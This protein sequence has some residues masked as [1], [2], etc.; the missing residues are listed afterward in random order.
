MPTF[1]CDDLHFV[2][3]VIGWFDKSP[4]GAANGFTRDIIGAI[5]FKVF[6]RDQTQRVRIRARAGRR[7]VGGER[8]LIKQSQALVRLA[9]AFMPASRSSA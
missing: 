7:V 6:D 3:L 4:P 9:K 8:Q 1:P 5:A 2:D